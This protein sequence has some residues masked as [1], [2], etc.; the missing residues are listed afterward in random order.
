MTH[1]PSATES[2]ETIRRIGAQLSS[3]DVAQVSAVRRGEELVRQKG[4][5]AA[6]EACRTC[7]WRRENAGTDDPLLDE[8]AVTHYWSRLRDSGPFSCH[9][10]AMLGELVTPEAE[11]CGW[12]ATSDD[13]TPRECTGALAQV[14]KEARLLEELGSYQA[15][16]EVRGPYG[17]SPAGFASLARRLRGESQPAP[18]SGILN[19]EQYG[20]DWFPEPNGRASAFIAPPCFCPVCEGHGEAHAQATLTTPAGDPLEV[21]AALAPLIALLWA[22]GGVTLASCESMAD[23][24]DKL[25]PANRSTILDPHSNAP[26]QMNYRSIVANDLAFVRGVNG[27][28]WEHLIEVAR[29]LDVEV[30][31]D[32]LGEG[33]QVAFPRDAITRLV[34]T[35]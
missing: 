14:L 16:L 12:K 6:V 4:Q 13:M 32:R 10:T 1:K 7:P 35:W 15:Y 24:I 8:K 20:R 11:A 28:A 33:V 23:A 18:R 22:N 31:V 30:E 29:R 2:L 9:K 3:A 34:E 5:P 26:E 19:P 25:W 27:T 17:V 21:D